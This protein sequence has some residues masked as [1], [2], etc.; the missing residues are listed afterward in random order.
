VPNAK[1][2][3]RRRKSTPAIPGIGKCAYLARNHL[4]AGFEVRVLHFLKK[5]PTFANKRP[6]PL[7]LNS[8]WRNRQNIALNRILDRGKNDQ[9]KS[10]T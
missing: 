1:A 2:F 7:N 5:N 4:P 9:L 8:H 10:S 3:D 6:M